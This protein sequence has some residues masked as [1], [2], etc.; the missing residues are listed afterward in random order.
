MDLIVDYLT[1]VFIPAFAL[2]QSGLLAGWTGWFAIIVIVFGSGV[3]FEA[4]LL[5]A[6][7]G[8]AA[9]E[10][11]LDVATRTYRERLTTEKTWIDL[12]GVS[13]T[14]IHRTGLHR[15]G[16][17]RSGI[18][19]T[20]VVTAT[21]FGSQTPTLTVGGTA[22]IN[23]AS[24]VTTGLQTYK[25]AVNLA[26]RL[27]ADAS[28]PPLEVGKNY[29]WYF[30]I[31]CNPR[32]DREDVLVSGWVE[33]VALSPTQKTQLEAASDRERLS[34]FAQQA[35]WYEYLATLAELR[36]SSPRDAALTLKWSELLNSVALGNIA[37][38]PLIQSK[39][40]PASR[41]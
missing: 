2:F 38:Q 41:N 30:T 20:G 28:S 18:S 6:D 3:Y 25:G 4:A 19:R 32:S 13:R 1:Y 22:N 34:I 12:T 11:L 37:Q 9:T 23:G 31:K 27:A 8:V 21:S 5:M 24:V 15:T 26:G 35:L 16:L 33:R 10:H 39:L 36:L 17:G 7:A 40:T 14:G 29:H